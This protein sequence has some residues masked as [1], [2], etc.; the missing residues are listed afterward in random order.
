[1]TARQVVLW[2]HGETDY[3]RQNRVQG[4]ID[5]DLNE[6]GRRQAKKAAKPRSTDGLVCG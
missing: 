2:R 5:I 1:M 4:S 3:N 6:H